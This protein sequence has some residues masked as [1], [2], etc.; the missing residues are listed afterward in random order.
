MS[1]RW[2]N[3]AVV[4]LWLSSMTWLVSTKLL[5]SWL[6]GEPPDSQKILRA[7]KSEPAVGWR[8]LWNGRNLGTAVTTTLPLPFDL[9]QVRS[10]IHFDRLPLADVAP[11]PV[12]AYFPDLDRIGALVKI[13]IQTDLDF[14]P[15][16]KLSRIDTVIGV[17]EGGRPVSLQ[18]RP[19]MHM[20]GAIDGPKMSVWIR[21]GDN[22]PWEKPDIPVPRDAMLRDA[23][24][25]QSQ[26]PGLHQGQTWTIETYNPMRLIATNDPKEVVHATVEGL[27]P[28]RWED[29]Q[30][31][32]WV[33][34]FRSDPGSSLVAGGD[35]RGKLWV[36]KDGRVLKQEMP[37]FDSTMVFARLPDKEAAAMAERAGITKPANGGFSR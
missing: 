2:Y 9:T 13:E 31:D 16:G 22:P 24:S 12:R 7:Q 23:F 20:R 14:D 5:P 34:V 8:I 10:V 4:L 1:S 18:P 3:A 28:V 36:A 15:L 30:L 21:V 33:V 11:S 19:P 26:L 17:P 25:P 37:L 29:G 32:A 6:R 35:V 27:A